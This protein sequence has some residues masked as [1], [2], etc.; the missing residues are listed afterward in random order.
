MKK[1]WV[2]VVAILLFTGCSKNYETMNDAYEP[3]EPAAV[4]TVVFS[5]PEDAAVPVISGDNG[6]IYFC[7]GYEI[8]VQTLNA[9]NLDKTLETLTGF[10]GDHLT[11]M[12]TS[13]GGIHRY[14][15]AW[16]AAGEG[17][18]QIGNVTILDDGNYHYCL[19]VL[20]PSQEA[21]SLQATWAAL[22]SS[23]QLQG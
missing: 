2:I 16:T 21:G 19:S 7:D 4:K 6:K 18:D 11:V 17:G 8:T 5:M 9:G 15:C 23:F 13:I 12:Q 3:I 14:S 10:I 1:L 20:A 22:M